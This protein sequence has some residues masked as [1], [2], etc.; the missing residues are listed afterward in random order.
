M[1]NLISSCTIQTPKKTSDSNVASKIR[2]CKSSRVAT[3][4]SPPLVFV[5]VLSSKRLLSTKIQI[6]VYLGNS[7]PGLQCLYVCFFFIN[8]I[9]RISAN[10]AGGRMR[11]Y[12]VHVSMLVAATL[13]RGQVHD[14]SA[15]ILPCPNNLLRVCWHAHG[16]L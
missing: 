11:W 14:M 15:Y 16:R 7:V 13:G 12:G 10:L 5:H 2:K 8:L 3:S 4:L 6:S 1:H 9:T